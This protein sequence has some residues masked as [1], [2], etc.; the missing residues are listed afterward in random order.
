MV[1][2]QNSKCKDPTLYAVRQ[3]QPPSQLSEVLGCTN[4]RLNYM[5]NRTLIF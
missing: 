2:L 4:T 3:I 5:Q 1:L